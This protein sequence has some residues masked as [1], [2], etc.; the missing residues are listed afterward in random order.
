LKAEVQEKEAAA[1]T[2]RAAKGLLTAQGVSLTEQQIAEVQTSVMASRAELAE[3][4]ARYKQVKDLIDSGGSADTIAA[5]LNSE[6]IRELR[7]QESSVAQRQADLENRYGPLHP[8]VEKV[9]LERTDIQTQIK[10]E[11]ARIAA[12]LRNE[13][14]VVRSRLQTLE[15]NLG[16]VRGNLISNNA[17]LVRLNELETDARAARSV[18]ESFLQRFHEVAQQGSLGAVEARI[19][20]QARTPNAPSSPNLSLALALSLVLGLGVAGAGALVA[21]QFNQGFTSAEDVERKIGLPALVSIPV[22]KDKDFCLLQASERHPAGYLVEKPMSAF[23]EAFRVLRTAVLYS[24]L[25]KTGKVVAFTSALPDEGKTTASLC[26]ARIS[27]L[28]GQSVILVDCDLRRRSLNEYFAISPKA[29][30][31]Q[32]LAGETD[33]RSV[34]GTDVASGVHVLPVADAGFTAKDIFGSEAMSRLMADLRGAYDIVILDCAPVLAVA[35]T[36]VAVTHAD[37]VV[38]AC[39]W[40]AT[41]S[42]ALSSAIVQLRSVDAKILGVA[43]N[44]VDP[45]A[46]GRSSYY[47]SL[48]YG[49]GGKY[50][51]G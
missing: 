9:R 24:T 15:S 49:A 1:Q 31:V 39:R 47:D 41:S 35:E 45:S 48:Y 22:L 18:Y 12:N 44:Y 28:S 37:A 8:S 25:N 27:A 34:V 13:A 46:P 38:L 42:K 32:V 7:S 26:L 2:Y 30:L 51:Q 36:R 3:K 17:E 43:L 4:Q 6:V 16:S 50:Y 20:S 5:V 10:S 23:A 29:G 21:E 19:V 11:I 33:W 40:G 14:E